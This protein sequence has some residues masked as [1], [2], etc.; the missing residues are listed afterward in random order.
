M[1]DKTDRKILETLQSDGRIKNTALSAHV[2]LSP[3]PC[4]NRVKKLEEADI[5]TGY[6]AIIDP[7]KVGLKVRALV[8]LKLTNNRR[9]AVD[10]FALAVEKVPAITECY[11]ATGNVDYVARIYAKDLED[12]ETI[13]KDDISEL[14]YLAS[15][16]TVFLFGNLKM[17]PEC[18]P[19]SKMDIS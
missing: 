19:L 14:P 13:I 2:N 8:L 4:L 7:A 1:L 17:A 16:E 6:K 10:E 5:I 15:M 11:L 12:Y 3:T 18:L 9:K